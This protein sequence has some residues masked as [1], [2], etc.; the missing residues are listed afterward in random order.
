M[1]IE[2]YAHIMSPPCRTVLLAAK[3]LNVEL[4]FKEIDMSKGDNLK[5]EFV[6]VGKD[7]DFKTM[8]VDDFV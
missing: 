5:P 2:F 3:A 8:Y 4:T 1:T 6:K 7:S